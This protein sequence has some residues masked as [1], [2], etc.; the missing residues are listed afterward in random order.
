MK[1]SLII[2]FILF[3]LFSCS[4]NKKN[5]IVENELINPNQNTKQDI[6]KTSRLDF[7]KDINTILIK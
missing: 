1:K 2:V 6:Y 5:N 7:E 4:D 3:F